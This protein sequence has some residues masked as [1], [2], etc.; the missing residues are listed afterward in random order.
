MMKRHIYLI[1]NP[2][3]TP[4]QV[5]FCSQSKAQRDAVYEELQECCDLEC[6]DC[7]VGQYSPDIIT[8]EEG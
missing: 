7:V 5:V 1:L 4:T 2:A 6:I 3:H 8:E